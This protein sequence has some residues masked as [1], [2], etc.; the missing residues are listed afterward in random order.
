MSACSVCWLTHIMCRAGSC[1]ALDRRA[2]P[3]RKPP[4]ATANAPNKNKEERLQGILQYRNLCVKV[5]IQAFFAQFSRFVSQTS[6]F[7]QDR[8]EAHVT[9]LMAA[10][11]PANP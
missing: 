8:C 7:S 5:C 1:C 11:A 9:R 3:E 6:R 10:D 2:L 4:T